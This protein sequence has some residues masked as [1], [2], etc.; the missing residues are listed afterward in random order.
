MIT[1]EAGTLFAGRYE[2]IRRL[3]AGGMGAVYLACDPNDREF[4][5]ALKLLYPGAIQSSKARERF[6]NEITASYRIKHPNVVRAYEYFDAEDVQAFAMEYIDGGDLLERLRDGRMA[7]SDALEI[8]KQLASALEAIHKAGIVHR[9][10]KPENI[11]LTRTGQVKITDFG[12]ARLRDSRTLTNAGSM[13]GTPKYLAPEYVET[14]ECDGRGDIFALG[15]IGYE[16]ISGQ[17]PFGKDFKP[18]NVLD[19]L[20]MQIPQLHEI[21]P[22]CPDDLSNIVHKSMSL[23]VLERYQS[24]SA[25]LNDIARFEDG[26]ALEDHQSEVSASDG[27]DSPILSSSSRD[28]WEAPARTNSRHDSA[29]SGGF[30]APPGMSHVAHHPPSRAVPVLAVTFAFCFLIGALGFASLILGRNSNPLRDM[31]PGVYQGA[32]SSTA[33]SRGR[34]PLGVWNFG[35]H[36]LLIIGQAGC[37]ADLFTTRGEYRCRADTY[38]FT[39][40]ATSSNSVSG[41]VQI[42]S[43]IAQ[44]WSVARFVEPQAAPLSQ[45]IS[46]IEDKSS[47]PPRAIKPASVS[48]PTASGTEERVPG[49]TPAQNESLSSI[50]AK[51]RSGQL[52]PEDAAH[53]LLKRTTPAQNGEGR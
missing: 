12:V 15:V 35:D 42:N 44:K 26:S 14:G 18:R 49:R 32:I 13:V 1:L 29:P 3:G 30:F 23:K 28:D 10:L 39:V 52:S 40:N 7:W 20:K 19:R 8:L 34:V 41:T 21:A 51:L 33:P 36:S 45:Q 53:L 43:A 27:D 24:A 11:M 31:T 38:R 17:S 16:L 6:R 48:A 22:D 46:E 37:A 5:V 50:E 9:D 4:K 25:L 2:V 47:P